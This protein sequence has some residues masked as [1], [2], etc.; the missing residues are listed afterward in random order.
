MI[1]ASCYL[2]ISHQL[3]SDEP[4]QGSNGKS[5]EIILDF[6]M[7]DYW[8][9]FNDEILVKLRIIRKLLS[10]TPEYDE[11]TEYYSDKIHGPR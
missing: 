6:A 8:M 3:I 10:H 2:N 9:I 5:F 4:H 7:N 11:R 1:F